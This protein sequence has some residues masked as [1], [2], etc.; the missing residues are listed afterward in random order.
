MQKHMGENNPRMSQIEFPIRRNTEKVDYLVINRTAYLV[1]DIDENWQN[2]HNDKNPDIEKYQSDYH[3]S[4]SERL[5]YVL[6]NGLKHLNLIF[7]P[8]IGIPI[9]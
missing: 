2:S 4:M 6:P 8:K 1:E 9:A 3:V 7:A 5:L